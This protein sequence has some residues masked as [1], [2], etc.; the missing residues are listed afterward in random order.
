MIPTDLLCFEPACE[1]PAD[2]TKHDTAPSPLIPTTCTVAVYS[3]YSFWPVSLKSMPKKL[4][5]E[6]WLPRSQRE[7]KQ[8]ENQC[9]NII[10]HVNWS[11]GFIANSEHE[12][13]Q[14]TVAD[15]ACFKWQDVLYGRQK[16]Q[17]AL[18][19]LNNAM[20]GGDWTRPSWVQLKSGKTIPFGGG[21]KSRVLR[22]TSLP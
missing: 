8:V 22:P 16:L 3:S 19:A 14:A 15:T 7:D 11:L 6:P 12:Y 13:K 5:G 10:F 9:R 20:S 17:Q 2:T 4:P 1:Q 18:G 21:R